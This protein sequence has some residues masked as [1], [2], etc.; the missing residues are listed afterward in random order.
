MHGELRYKLGMTGVVRYLS[1][2]E[3]FRVRLAVCLPVERVE[4]VVY[5]EV[6]LAPLNKLLRDLL[7]FAGLVVLNESL[8]QQE[9]CLGLIRP[10]RFRAAQKCGG[11]SR[12]AICESQVGLYDQ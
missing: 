6:C 11:Q 5:R 2:Q 10:R 12:M 9:R 1:S 3:S 8:G 7:P 4:N